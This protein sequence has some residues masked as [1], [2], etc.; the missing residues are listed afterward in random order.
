[1]TEAVLA[2]SSA[3]SVV[4]DVGA[5]VG[6]LVL[7]TPPDLDGVEI[8]I[9]LNG[10]AAAARL[11]SRVP[12]RR[13]GAGMWFAAVYP[14]L[15]AGRYTSW[16][17]A[18][19]SVAAATITSGGVT[20]QHWQAR[21]GPP[22]GRAD[23]VPGAADGAARAALPTRP[24]RF[25]WQNAVRVSPTSRTVPRPA[26]RGGHPHHDLVHGRARVRDRRT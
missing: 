24:S 25:T 2:P 20:L 7:R 4:L 23:R 11:H 10:C 9:S 14:G 21:P 13:T 15:P 19:T 8:E 1:M 16:R 3:G 12:E 5:G 22:A 26:A 6:A 18:C 17:D